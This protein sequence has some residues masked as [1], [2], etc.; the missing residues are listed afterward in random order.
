V[1]ADTYLR[2]IRDFDVQAAYQAMK[3]SALTETHNPLRPENSDYLKLGYVPVDDEGPFD[4]SVSTSLEYY[5]ADAAIGRLA[6]ALNQPEDAAFF[7]QKSLN[8]QKL[9]DVKTGMLRPKKRSSDWHSPFNPDGG[10]NFEPT[11]GYIEG[12]AWNYRFYVPHDTAGL[13]KLLGEDEFIRQLDLTFDSGKFDM[14]NEPDIT[15][16]FLYNYLPNNP[17]QTQKTSARVK[18]LIAKHYHNTPAGLP[19][20]D[21]TGTLSSWLVFSMLGLYPT[22]PGNPQYTVFSPTVKRARIRLHP[23]YYPGKMLEI[24]Q[25][26]NST[27]PVN[28]GPFNSWQNQPLTTPF[29]SHEQLVQGGTLRLQ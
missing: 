10:R 3:K 5:L 15:Y 26:T 22:D 16:P 12:T 25:N 1:I 27:G 17:E 2:G 24:Q 20:N 23:A 6:A 18:Q 21:D 29:I 11:A 4:G 14:A 28:Q 8:Y 7:E 19:G 9:F 13:I